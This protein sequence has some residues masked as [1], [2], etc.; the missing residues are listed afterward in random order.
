MYWNWINIRYFFQILSLAIS[1]LY[2]KGFWS[3]KIYDGNFKSVCVPFLNCYSCPGAIFSCPLGAVQTVINN[4]IT[5]ELPENYSQ[6]GNIKKAFYKI[7]SLASSIPVFVIGFMTIVGIILG[8]IPCGI[9]CPFGFFQDLLYK[10]PTFKIIKYPSFLNYCKYLILVIFVILLPILYVDNMGISEPYFCKLICPAG[11]LQ[12]GILLPLLNPDL[13]SVLGKLFVWKMS[14][15]IFFIALAVLIKRPFCNW[16]CPIGAYLG[17]F[18]KISFVKF[19][20]EKENC[21]RCEI[22]NK[23]CIVGIDPKSEIDSTNCV[24]CGLCV[25]S[26][27]KNII[28]VEVK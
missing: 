7:L 27:P 14:V 9:L 22:C 13:R 20:V 25:S 12:G 11:T 18:N 23:K 6:L 4:G 3:G 15:L 5:Y 21:I 19:K 16:A 17:L 2:L 10:I 26:C 28:K 24:R 1:N 8:R